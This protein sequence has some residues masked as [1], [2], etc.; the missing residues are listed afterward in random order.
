MLRHLKI[1]VVLSALAL[2]SLGL[3]TTPASAAGFGPI[4]HAVTG[5]CIDE[6]DRTLIQLWQCHG[7]ANQNWIKIPA[8]GGFRLL[9]QDSGLCLDVRIGA[10]PVPNGTPLQGW[11]CD[12]GAAVWQL[13]DPFGNTGQIVDVASG[14][15]I[16][17]DGGNSA[18]G[19]K[20]QMWDCITNNTN[21]IWT[22]PA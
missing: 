5:K 6:A 13:K 11:P 14:K 3:V 20:I 2:G 17:L 19:A 18:N 7:G 9:N 15:C 1:A 8:P 4:K 22:L 12:Q 16:D 21:Q 10:P